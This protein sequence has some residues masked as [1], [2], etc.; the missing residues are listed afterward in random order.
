MNS[1]AMPIS[2]RI[3]STP[4]LLQAFQR[5]GRRRA[6]RHQFKILFGCQQPRQAL[7]KK[8]VIVEQDQPYSR[9]P[10]D[11]RVCSGMDSS[12]ENSMH[13]MVGRIGPSAK[14]FGRKITVR[15]SNAD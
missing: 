3:T 10:F 15:S 12:F 11:R 2:T 9:W 8:H 1:L 6:F 4:E 13:S 5:L 14:P 7:A